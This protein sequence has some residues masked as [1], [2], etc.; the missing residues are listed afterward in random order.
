MGIKNTCNRNKNDDATQKE[1]STGPVLAIAV[2][3]QKDP[4]SDKCLSSWV[5]LARD[6]DIQSIV[7]L[8]CANRSYNVNYS[9]KS[10]NHK[11]RQFNPPSSWCLW[12][13]SA[14]YT[15]R[16][17][18]KYLDLTNLVWRERIPLI[19]ITENWKCEWCSLAAFGQPDFRLFL[20]VS[21]YYDK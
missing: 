21:Q 14:W 8:G 17:V 3:H 16:A 15:R 12:Q 19:G 11:H 5:L 1:K 6:S 20:E 18:D 4:E 2:V 13:V 7:R 9:E 10:A